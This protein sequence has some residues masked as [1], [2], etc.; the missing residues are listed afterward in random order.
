ML[1]YRIFSILSTEN[2]KMKLQNNQLFMIYTYFS[3]K[4]LYIA[5]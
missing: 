2:E 5:K 3:K 4:Q 1:F